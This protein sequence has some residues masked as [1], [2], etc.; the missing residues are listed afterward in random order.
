MLPEVVHQILQSTRTATPPRKLVLPP[1]INGI[2]FL[3]LSGEVVYVGQ[4]SDIVQRI[5]THI[6][7]RDMAFDD[8]VYV[9]CADEETDAL[10]GTL[11]RFLKPRC[12]TQT[13]CSAGRNA[14]RTKALLQSAVDHLASVAEAGATFQEILVAV[15][16]GTRNWQAFGRHLAAHPRARWDQS[17]AR[18][19]H[20]PSETPV[21]S[22]G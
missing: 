8:V 12:N 5:Y 13:W 20:V 1:R 9:E 11:I 14:R 10:E 19:F 22:P 18:Y 6:D 16:A 17:V 2:Y 4:S 15:G 3:I 21:P 7:H